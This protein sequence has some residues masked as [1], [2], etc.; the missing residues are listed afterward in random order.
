[1]TT[2]ENDIRRFDTKDFALVRVAKV[3]A[4][5]FDP[6]AY[7][8]TR[9]DLVQSDNFPLFRRLACQGAI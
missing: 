1:V 5:V 2:F 7:K 4:M 9:L 3:C 6:D 8:V